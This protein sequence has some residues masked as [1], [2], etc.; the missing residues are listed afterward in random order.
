V[1]NIKNII[2]LNILVLAETTAGLTMDKLHPIFN[3][4]RANKK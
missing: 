4:K 2:D 1:V 3:V